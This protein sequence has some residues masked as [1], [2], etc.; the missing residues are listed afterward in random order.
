MKPS[1]ASEGC[2]FVVDD[3]VSV[4]EALT[5]LFRS[6]GLSVQ[7][8]RTASEFLSIE[9]PDCPCCLVLDLRLPG[10]SGMDLQQHLTGTTLEMPIIFIT[11]HGDV[12]TS[13]RA[14]K[15]GAVEFLTKPFGDQ[16]LLDA[17]QHAI[18]RDREDGKR[19]ASLAAL[20]SRYQTLTAREQ[21]VL[22]YVVK[23]LAN[24]M[25]AGELDITEP[26]VKLHRGRVMKKM[27]AESLAELIG[28]AEQLGIVQDFRAPQHYT[29]V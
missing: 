29:K 8:F 11:A 22:V 5:N 6:V 18:E 20:R 10:I 23:G 1:P 13:V 21:D 28:M 12:R 9:K 26:T 19:R 4:R 15:A 3:D 25:T 24:K 27:Q 17:V 14:M 2:V 7:T 16:E